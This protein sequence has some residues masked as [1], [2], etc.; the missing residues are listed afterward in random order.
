MTTNYSHIS[1]LAFDLNRNIGRDAA[2]LTALLLAIVAIYLHLLSGFWREDDTFLVL[3]SLDFNWLDAFFVPDAWQRI[4]PSNLTPWII[5][6]FKFD[7]V[8]GGI[9]PRFFY[10][11]QLISLCIV[12]GATY[13]LCRLWLP[14]LWAFLAVALF[15]LGAPTDTVVE[16]LMTRHYLE[17]MFFALVALIAFNQAIRTRQFAWS[18]ASAFAYALAVTAKEIYVPLCLIILAIPPVRSPSSRFRLALPI[19]VVA[20]LY[21]FWRRYML[22]EAI[23]GYTDSQTLISLGSLKNVAWAILRTPEVLFGSPW[24][25]YSIFLICCIALL[26]IKNASALIGKIRPIVLLTIVVVVSVVAPIA[27]LAVSGGTVTGRH[28]FLIWFVV[29]LAC[30]T[31]IRASSA[32]ASNSKPLQLA[33]GVALSLILI[34]ST[35][36]HARNLASSDRK[37][38][39]EYDA[40][41][42]FIMDADS[43]K[44]FIPPQHILEQYWYVYCL[45]E[46]KARQGLECPTGLIKG[47]PVRNNI[48]AL[49]MYDTETLSMVDISLRT[50]DAIAWVQDVDHTRPLA[51]SMSI[52]DGWMY[53]NLSPYDGGQYYLTNLRWG[54]KPVK[55]LGKQRWA[56]K[57]DLPIYVQYDSPS[58]WTTTSPLFILN[59][60]APIIWARNQ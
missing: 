25:I 33:L 9:E 55:K 39:K 2:V 22:G 24:K 6:S 48:T 34:A 57:T 54:R 43:S 47:L 13:L 12:V 40:L 37:H 11:H 3:R 38:S 44:A 46:L 16:N 60:N 42:R 19:L 7:L 52:D 28:L 59:G 17:G 35:T 36:I 4:T 56:H 14:P 15:M 50:N 41:G 21:I 10:A 53:W 1:S 26:F 31:S 20:A 23:G 27:P 8:L 51:V 49:Y 29:S 45:C 30:I 58:G 32:L 18:I 5:P